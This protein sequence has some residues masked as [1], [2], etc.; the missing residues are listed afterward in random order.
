[1]VLIP[2]S[3]LSKHSHGHR[4]EEMKQQLD[5]AMPSRRQVFRL[6]KNGGITSYTFWMNCELKNGCPIQQHSRM[7]LSQY[8]NN[9]CITKTSTHA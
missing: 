8:E 9:T 3:A 2:R 1:M 7:S 5:K 6:A 4:L